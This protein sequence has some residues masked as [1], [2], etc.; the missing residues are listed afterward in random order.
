[1]QGDGRGCIIGSSNR[2]HGLSDEELHLLSQ[3]FNTEANIISCA[4]VISKKAFIPNKDQFNEL[5]LRKGESFIAIYNGVQQVFSAEQFIAVQTIN[6]CPVGVV[7]QLRPHPFVLNGNVKKTHYWTGFEIVSTNPTPETI[8]IKLADIKRKVILGAG[9][10]EESIDSIVIDYKRPMAV[11]QEPVV[12][13][14]P[15]N[16]DM[17]AIQ[18]EELEDTWFGLVI[19]VNARAKQVTV[20]F[21][22]ESTRWPGRN[23]YVRESHGHSARETV[24]WKSVLSIL[25]GEWISGST[26]KLL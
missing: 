11:G 4:S 15:E 22:V 6:G 8:M 14:S 25:R 7:A 12:P 18:G 20:N 24:H 19:D 1:L 16:G 10:N 21:F 26:W 17:L 9:V 2:V 3:I 5:L 13:C 23:L